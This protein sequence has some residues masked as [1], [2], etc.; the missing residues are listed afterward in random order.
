MPMRH[1][2]GRRGCGGRKL[3]R[4]I[5]LTLN[6]RSSLGINPAD[7][8]APRAG[9]PRRPPWRRRLKPRRR[10]GQ[11][12]DR[13]PLKEKRDNDGKRDRTGKAGGRRMAPSRFLHFFVLVPSPGRVSFPFLVPEQL[14][15]RIDFPTNCK[16]END[17]H[18]YAGFNVHTRWPILPRRLSVFSPPPR[19]SRGRRRSRRRTRSFVLCSL[20]CVCT[21]VAPR[22]LGGAGAEGG[23]RRR[24]CDCGKR[25]RRLEGQEAPEGGVARRLTARGKVRAPAAKGRRRRGVPL[26]RSRGRRRRE[27]PVRST[28]EN[29]FDF[30]QRPCWPCPREK[31]A[32][33]ALFHYSP[34]PHSLSHVFISSYMI[35]CVNCPG[36]MQI[37]PRG[38][39]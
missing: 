15:R 9:T 17:I 2:S 21:H 34:S 7:R 12:R 38:P 25:R 16:R 22:D 19:V 8:L 35:T 24:R 1:A 32:G 13:R 3:L 37:V 26:L 10:R 14:F 11:T 29:R 30:C 4:M 33:V 27:E 18:S 20:V 28:R 5:F 23:R 6:D 31:P 36:K 39:A